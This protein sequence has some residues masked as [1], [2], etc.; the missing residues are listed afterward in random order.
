MHRPMARS[1]VPDTVPSAWSSREPARELLV[2]SASETDRWS[3]LSAA[4]LGP[5]LLRLRAGDALVVPPEDTHRPRGLAVRAVPGDGACFLVELT[6]E[7]GT[8]QIGT[9]S[10]PQAPVTVVSRVTRECGHAPVVRVGPGWRHTALTA[11]AL[12][13]SWLL[14][15]NVGAQYSIAPYLCGGSCQEQ[16]TA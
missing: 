15:G 6:G 11:Q 4:A 10:D 8:H 3:P 2:M 7:L 12:V 16:R 9:T 13:L 5:H 1:A 14:R